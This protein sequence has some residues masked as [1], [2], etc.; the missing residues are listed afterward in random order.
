MDRGTL[1]EIMV[2]TR[3]GCHPEPHVRGELKKGPREEGRQNFGDN[4]LGGEG[5]L[6]NRLIRGARIT[7]WLTRLGGSSVSSAVGGG[8]KTARTTDRTEKACW[9]QATKER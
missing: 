2:I 9:T 3:R 8:R 6:K 4:Q 7:R 1:K 5:L